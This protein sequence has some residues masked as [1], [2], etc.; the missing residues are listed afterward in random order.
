MTILMPPVVQRPTPNYTRTAIAHDLIVVHRTEGGYA[1]ACAWLCDPRA[2]AS[3]HLVMKA[4]GSEVTQLVPL[5]FKAWHACNFNGRSLGLEVEGF[6]RDGFGGD[7]ARAAARIVAWL[8]REYGIPP[9]WAR[10]GQGRGVCQHHDLG[11]AGGGLTV[12]AQ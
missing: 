5:Q 3:A 9:T 12:G 4:D 6:T 11:A 1:G 7:T 2:K 8:C 10:G